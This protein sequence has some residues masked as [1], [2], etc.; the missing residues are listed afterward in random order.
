MTDELSTL[1]KALGYPIRRKIL[2]VL[3]VSPQTTG[4]LHEFFP[5]VSRYA[6]MKHLKVLEEGNL[7]VI[8]RE[9]KFRKAF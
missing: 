7:L 9:G 4:E 3:K 5:E 1:F 6:I 2:D 8:R